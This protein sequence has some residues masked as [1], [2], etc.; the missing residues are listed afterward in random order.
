MKIY[1]KISE[2]KEALKNIKKDGNDIGLVPTMGF[3]HE[4][5]L[6]LV[7]QSVKDNT[8]T[9]V[10]V[11]VNPLQF[12]EGEDFDIYPRDFNK[13][14]E[15]LESEN[16]DIVFHPTV[17]GL[18]R[19]NF[20]TKICVKGMTE[21][22]CGLKRPGHFEGVC[23]VVSKLFNIIMPDRAYFGMKDYQQLQIIK[24][25]VDDLNYDIEIIGM[26]IIRENN[27]LAMSSRNAYL[28]DKKR[29]DAVCLFSSFSLVDKLLRE[30]IR[31]SESIVIYIKKFIQ[32]F[33]DTKID[34]VE[35]VDPKTLDKIT[36][37]AGNFLLVLAVYIGETRLIDNKIF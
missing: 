1:T 32:S 19:D 12:G 30:G 14:C 28:G 29:K 17:E 26:S 8:T 4:G 6:S 16:V 31:E 7:R 9:A 15:L 24:K 22:L 25:L 18:Y 27:G 20:S 23:T 36:H 13:D 11:F 5:H 10:S 34:Y 35:I 33:E 2:C 3:L 21:K 37:I